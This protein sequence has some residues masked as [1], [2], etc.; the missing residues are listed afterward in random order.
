MEEVA[1]VFVGLVATFPMTIQIAIV[2]I[3]LIG[4]LLFLG[5]SFLAAVKGMKFDAPKRRKRK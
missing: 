2:F 5:R 3:V 1:I 4:G